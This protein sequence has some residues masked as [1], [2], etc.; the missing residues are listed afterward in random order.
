MTVTVESAELS[1]VIG[2]I[3]DSAVDPSLWPAALESCCGLIGANLGSVALFELRQQTTRWAVQW[4]GD[5]YW[6]KLYEEKY[7]AM[8]PFWPNLTREEV[9]SIKNTRDM[10]K[11]LGG[12]E[13]EIRNRPFFTEWAAPAGYHDVAAC[14]IARNETRR[15]VFQ[16][17][18]PLTREVVGPRD[19]AIVNLLFPHVRRAVLIGDLLDMRS[20]ASTAFTATLDALTVAVILVDAQSRILHANTAAQKMFSAGGPVLSIRNEL[21]THQPVATA[22][23]RDAI[24]RA[25]VNESRLSHGGIGVPIRGREIDASTRS[26]AHVLPLKSGTLRPGLALGAAAAVFVTPPGESSPPPFEA[27]AALYDLTPMEARVMIEIASGKNRAAAAVTLGIADSTVKTHLARVFEKTRTSDQ[28]ELAKL[29]T[30][31]TP[32]VVHP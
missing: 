4:G 17:H 30:S 5:P 20:I 16:L 24:G 19:I 7:A 32:P 25:A 6:M 21:N 1:Q 23:L 13:E 26:M 10:V 8:M 27:L 22:A 31:L 9:G 29:V 12:D 11:V 2:R 28:S 15:G 18:T 3:Y 14:I